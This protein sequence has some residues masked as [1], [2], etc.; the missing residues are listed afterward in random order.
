MP[1]DS[2][3]SIRFGFATGK[4][5]GASWNEDFSCVVINTGTNSNSDNGWD[6][7]ISLVTP[8]DGGGQFIVYVVGENGAG[9]R[10]FA[11][12]SPAPN[13]GYTSTYDLKACG[14]LHVEMDYGSRTITLHGK[15]LV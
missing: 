7:G 15:S 12:S 4:S 1:Q 6:M 2:A 10:Q 14:I 3:Q 8:N 5:G 9:T 13:N 11:Y